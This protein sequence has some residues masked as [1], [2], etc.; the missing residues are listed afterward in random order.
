M[1]KRVIVLINLFRRKSG[2][3]PVMS[4]RQLMVGKKLKT[5]L[6][7]IGKLVMA[8]D[9][10]SNN[11]TARPRV[12]F[13]LYIGPNASGIGHAVFKLSTKLLVTTPKYRPKSMA[14]DIV[15]VVNDIRKDEGMLDGIQFNNIHYKLS[16]SYLYI[17]EV[18][19]V[20]IVMRPTTTGTIKKGLSKMRDK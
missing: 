17:D 14:D 9:V 15:A 16:L 7:K 2:V 10:T 4:P 19:H 1:V 20:T 3:H 8:Y 5:P 12:F 18:G 11:V 13:A 6:C